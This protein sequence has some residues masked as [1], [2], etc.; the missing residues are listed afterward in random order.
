MNESSL[1]RF[2]IYGGIRIIQMIIGFVGNGLTIHIIRNLKV[3]T[4]GHILM[5]YM[6]IAQILVNC[7]VP[8]ATFADYT[9]TLENSSKYNWKAVTLCKDCMYFFTFALTWVC[10]FTLSVDRSVH[11]FCVKTVVY[12]SL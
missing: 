9:G 5:T 10:Y 7:V 2:A 1:Y 3:L 6:A 8:L 11:L 4:N 12:I